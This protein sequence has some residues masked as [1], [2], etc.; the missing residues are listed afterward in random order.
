MQPSWSLSDEDRRALE[1]PAPS[2]EVSPHRMLRE[3]TDQADVPS[4]RRKWKD[5]AEDETSRS[6]TGQAP[7]LWQLLNLLHAV[8]MRYLL[9]NDAKLHGH[10]RMETSA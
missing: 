1:E 9:Q 8:C 5:H 4:L 6:P 2:P 3:Q 7:A 10:R